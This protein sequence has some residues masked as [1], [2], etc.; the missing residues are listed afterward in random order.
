M[1]IQS[2]VAVALRLS[3]LNFLLWTVLESLPVLV[4]LVQVTGSPQNLD[5][6]VWLTVGL[7]LSATLGM[8]VFAIPLSRLVAKGLPRDTGTGLFSLA[9][10]YSVAFIGF[11]VYFGIL[12]AP[13]ALAWGIHLLK[14]AASGGDSWKEGINMNDL[15]HAM[16]PFVAGLTLFFKGRR[17]AVS[18]AAAHTLQGGVRD[19]VSTP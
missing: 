10:G 7:L 18:L 11:E 13:H 15:L 4:R 2:L 6:G 14:S 5:F 19:T 16:V 1:N 17:W 9:D 12:H 8:W 3:A